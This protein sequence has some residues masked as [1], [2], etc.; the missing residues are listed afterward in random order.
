MALSHRWGSAECQLRTESSTLEKFEH[1]LP[2]E[3]MPKT[4]RDAITVTRRLDIRYL[5]IDS[6]CILQDDPD[7]WKR[8]SLKMG[9]IFES[10]ICTIAATDAL[11][12]DG[13]DCGL[14]LPRDADPLAI[15]LCLP[16]DKI[17]LNGLSLKVFRR[18]DQVFV[19]KYRWPAQPSSTE[20]A[21]L[22]HKRA[23]ICLHPR[24]TSLYWRVRHSLWYNRG[25]VLQERIL[26]PRIIYFTKDKLFWSCFTTTREEE[27]SDPT[28][29][30]RKCIFSPCV[31]ESESSLDYW[32]DILFD[33]AGCNLTF[34]KD[35]LAAIDGITHQFEDYYSVRICAGIFHDA[36]GESLLWYTNKQ[37]LQ[38][39]SDFHAP[40][41]S[42]AS[43]A[44]SIGFSLAPPLMAEHRFLIRDLLYE[45]TNMCPLRSLQ[46]TCGNT[47]ISGVFHLLA[48]WED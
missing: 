23:S 28:S 46:G 17:P 21:G 14:F 33:Y 3:L 40:S 2:M 27:N 19:W 15:D 30:H 39:F 13:R 16:Y 10:C 4:F 43:L 9:A 1:E 44:G 48:Q 35:R 5:W 38:N 11:N 34:G 32:M 20:L 42:W 36:N 6:L 8:E 37:P 25:W 26:S 31:R 7:D 22:A 24:I 12:D 45:V 47:C 18:G 29:P 41:W